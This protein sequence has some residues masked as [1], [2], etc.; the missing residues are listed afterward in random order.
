MQN[1][2]HK[3]ELPKIEYSNDTK[4]P[5]LR[6]LDGCYEEIRKLDKNTAISKYYIRQ[7]VLSGVLPRIK[8]GKKYLI[9][10]DLLIEYLTNPEADK[11]KPCNAAPID[12]GIRKIM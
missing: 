7:L 6:T 3:L 9:N 5:R 12:N 1:N 8:A 4:L 11:F 2:L 10:L